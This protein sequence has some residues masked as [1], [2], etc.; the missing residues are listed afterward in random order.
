M[1]VFKCIPPLVRNSLEGLRSEFRYGH[2]LVFCWLVFLHIVSPDLANLKSLSL[3]CFNLDYARFIRFMKASYFDPHKWVSWMARQA[4]AHL[5]HEDTH[6]KI[7]ADC[8]MCLKR[9]YRNPLVTTTKNRSKGPYLNGLHLLVISFQWH[10]FRVPVRFAIIRKKGTLGYQKPNTVLLNLLAE[11]EIPVWVKQVT[12][13]A[14][15]AFVSKTVCRKLQGWNWGYVLRLPKTWKLATGNRPVK[16]LCQSLQRKHFQRTWFTPAHSKRRR[17]C[18]VYTLQTSLRELGHVTLVFSTLAFNSGHKAIRILVTNTSF[19]TTKILALY[20]RRWATE[21]L[22]REL[23]SGMGLAQHQVCS[24]PK[25]IETSIAIPIVAYNLLIKLSANEIPLQNSWSIFKLKQR[26]V[27]LCMRPDFIHF[28]QF[29]NR[30]A[31]DDSLAHY[32]TA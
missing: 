16:E 2:F 22:F 24:H 14:D 18:Y 10:N 30:K 26:F 7:V 25:Q 21:V 1:C 32:K 11:L 31:H 15:A 28:G 8:T 5:S 13:L 3:K 6:L 19:S 4:I 27:T 20:Q 17:T 29:N 12:F 9:S 23:K